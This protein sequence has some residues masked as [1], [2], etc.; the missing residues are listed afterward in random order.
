MGIAALPPPALHR[1]ADTLRFVL[2]AWR[3]IT[4]REALTALAIAAFGSTMTV[5]AGL[6][7]LVK[8]DSGLPMLAH[9]IGWLFVTCGAGLL[10]WV[11]ADRA[12]GDDA[13]RWRRMLV[14]LMAATVTATAVLPLAAYELLGLPVPEKEMKIDGALRPLPP[15]WVQQARTL[16]TALIFG[17]LIFGVVE[18]L[19][20]RRLANE[21]LAGVQHAREDLA[22]RALQAR[23][24]VL[25]AQVEPRVLFDT[26]VEVD[27]LY[28]RDRGKAA[29]MLDQLITY[30]RVA[31]PQLR[32]SGS[33]AQAEADLVAAYLRVVAA[34]H[35]G[36]PRAQIVVDPDAGAA[37]FCPMLLLPLVQRA[38]RAVDGSA[39]RLPAAIQ[40]V[41]K[42]QG[43][44]LVALLRIDA[45]GQCNNDAELDRLRE[46]LAALYGPRAILSCAE[47]A[48]G[49]S[50]FSLRLPY[51]PAQPARPATESR[52]RPDGSGG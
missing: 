3:S 43:D 34:R 5:L 41:L 22:R 21:A 29:A 6:D 35:D 13:Q 12:G 20:R 30:L 45:R 7:M 9:A 8:L 44:T 16:V 37:R 36:L 48:R 31:L 32:D 27:A 19:R 26:L 40:L 10:A 49:I 15:L 50:E 17:G 18:A 4:G 23:L 51:E 24:A 38:V 1:A 39:G 28:Q 25:Q 47:S 2:A 11:L 42:R 46:R 33:S 52:H 14:A